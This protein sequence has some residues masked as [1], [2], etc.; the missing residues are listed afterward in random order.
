MMA[1]ALLV[2]LWGGYI[3]GWQWTG[4][5][6]NG[7]VWDW[8]SLLLLPVVLGTIPLWIR[9]KKYIGRRRRVIYA[10]V[11]VGWAGFMIAGYLI[12]LTWTGFRDQK[13][14]NWLGLVVLPAA[15]A[16]AMT[17]FDV[18]AR[19]VKIRLRPYQTALIAAL[20]AGWVVTIIGGY[21]LHWAWTGYGIPPLN[22]L[23]DWLALLLPL[24]FPIILLPPLVKWVS[25]NAAGRASAAQEAAVARGVTGGGAG[26]N[27]N[28]NRPALWSLPGNGV[29]ARQGDLILLSAIDERG[30]AEKLLDLLAKTSEGGGDGRRFAAAVEDLVEGDEAWGSG[31]EGQRGSAVVAFGPVGAGLTVIVSG[32]AWAEIVTACGTDRLVAGQP[33]TVLRCVVGV[34]V[35]AVRG[36]LGTGGGGGDRTDRFSRLERG[37]VR[38]GGLSYH[39]GL[40]AEPPP[41]GAA[42]EAVAPTATS[43]GE[44]A[45]QS[46]LRRTWIAIAVA[47]VLAAIAVG[48]YLLLGGDGK[49]SPPAALPYSCRAH[50]ATAFATARPLPCV[51]LRWTALK[52][53]PFDAAVAGDFAFVSY[54]NGL[55]VLNMAR[56]PA[57]IV[58]LIPL[59]RALGEALTPGNKYLLVSG[60][61]G[62]A[63]FKVSDLIRGK[64][65]PFKLLSS[66]GGQYAVEVAVTPDGK[67]AYVTLQHSNQVA[68]FGLSRALASQAYESA[69]VRKIKVGPNPIG[70]AAAP[71]GSYLYVATGLGD[72]CT[73]SGK[74]SLVV[75][76]AATAE[77]NAPGPPIKA[78]LNTG[79]GLARVITS[80]DGND[81]WATAGCGNT[82]QAYSAARLIHDP[83]SAQIAQVEVGQAPLGLVMVDHGRQIVLADS[84]RYHA[85]ALSDLA[86]VDVSK[87]LA[88]K[89]AVLG[90]IKSGKVPRQF[91]LT[92]DGTTLLVTNTN[93]ENVEVLDVRQLP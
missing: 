51:H 54:G 38:A 29:L 69:P 3:R 25:G 67:F 58:H 10:V 30:L 48:G 84:D 73:T 92:P 71:D 28:V 27:E 64:P 59:A 74:G 33:A 68:V 16:T 57:K 66:P 17:L 19:G 85:G 20:A 89:P 53:K 44:V 15:V 76:D 13:L 12:P 7:Q 11:V 21:A 55:A 42:P 14:S 91:A 80:H 31:R 62:A 45:A 72:S 90:T 52:G 81:V 65:S 82:L 79:S 6:E 93:S 2:V 88:H 87:A 1:A 9:Y 24:V 61:K 5:R 47:G 18:S 56:P 34:P 22:T 36:G 26:V 39:C 4:F 70:I 77:G 78:K 46:T 49:A 50:P 75:L 32:T 23:W 41:D 63:V 83:Q 37:T 86:L 35:H 43:P 8:L 40:P 60:G